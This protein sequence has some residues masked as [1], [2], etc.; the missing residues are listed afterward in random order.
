MPFCPAQLG[1]VCFAIVLLCSSA[2]AATLWNDLGA[3]LAHDT[4]DGQD[5]L[6]G[7][8]KR[9]DTS[10]DTLYFKFHVDPLSDVN[11]EEYF[12]GLELFDGE[13][14][15]LAVGNSMKAWAYSAF[16]TSEV[17]ELNTV[18]GDFDLHS[19]RPELTAVGVFKRYE[20][21]RRG[22]E[23]TIVFRVQYVPGEDDFVTVWLSP[24]LSPG[25]TETN[26]PE[27]LT[28]TFKA[29]CSF[30]EIHLRHGGGGDG[31]TFSDIAIATSFNDF[32]APSG[33]EP[34]KSSPVAGQGLLPFTFRSW[35][36]E[37]GLPQNSVRAL[38]QT[39]EGYLWIG[40]DN[41]LARFDGVRFVS[42]GE[43]EGLRCGAVSGI[44]EDR[45]GA[46]WIG[47][48][49]DGLTRWQDGKFITF[50]TKDGLPADSITA[51]AEDNDGRLWVGTAAGMGSLLDGRWTTLT[52]ETVLGKTITG[53]FEDKKG[54]LWVAVK[55]TGVFQF[56]DGKL[57]PV[58]DG[59]AE[60]LLRDPHCLLVDRHD[61]LW[62]GV[63][64][65]F[66]LCRDGSQWNR[67]RIPRH[68][69]RPFISTLAES[70]DGTVW[71]GSVSEGLFQFNDGKLIAINASSG[72]L[73]NVVESL[74]VDREG[75]LWV[76]TSAGLNQ[77][78]PKSVSCFGPEEGLGFG[79]VQGLAEIAP[80]KIWAGKASDGLYHWEGRNFS[81]LSL[82]GLSRNETQVNAVLATRD[83]G[84]WV[85]SGKGLLHVE[86][87]K[88]GALESQPTVLS[89]L[90]AISLAEDRDGAVW[91]GTHEGGVWRL[92][93]G[94]QTAMT[95]LWQ[96]RPVTAILQ[97]GDGSMWIGTD[98]DGLH[99][100]QGSAHI[101]YSKANGL[102]NDAIRAL[103]QDA[104]GVLW[105]GTA[106]GGLARW[107]DGNITVFT[108][109]EGL[110]DDTISQIIEDDAGRL[111]LGSNRGIASVSKVELQELAAGKTTTLYPRIFG[112]AEGMLSEECTGGFFPAGLKTKNGLLWFSTVKG[113]VV[114]DPYLKNAARRGPTVILEEVTL[115]GAPITAFPGADSKTENQKSNAGLP[116]LRIPPGQ[117]RI[118]LRYAGLN[119]TAPERVRF[120]YRLEGLDSD[121]VDAGGS[122]NVSY[123]FVP[124]GK[125]QFQVIACD[126]D[127]VWSESG[128]GVELTVLRYFWQTWWFIG[129]A[130]FGF[131]VFVGGTIR[132]L[133]RRKAQGQLKQL[134]RARE[135]ERERARIA[136]DLHD[137]LG[138]SLSR[139]SL[140]SDM[141]RVGQD[142]H[143][144]TGVHVD[145][146]SHLAGQTLR[147]LDEIVWAVRPGSDSLQSLVEY[148]A[149]FAGELFKGSGVRCRLD[150]P[151]TLPARSL[152]PEMRHNIFLIAK[153]ALTNTMKHASAS[154]VTVQ[155][156][157]D[158]NSLEI[159]IGDDGNG[160]DPSNSQSIREGNGLGN[161][162][163]RAEAVGGNLEMKSAP[164]KGTT[165]R[166]LVNFSQQQTSNGKRS[167]L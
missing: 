133:E 95:N 66:V 126:G 108:T 61:R 81:R 83:G 130:T 88:A 164:G 71:A 110:P 159:L 86:D 25:A 4:G 109:R 58:K 73:D 162:R 15:G 167:I 31:W 143:S 6:G 13:T 166:L 27:N 121:W 141:A 44:L 14:R 9:D 76:G 37:Q 16:H 39:R 60:R 97:G 142:S 3:T 54:I 135:L 127:G 79:A 158:A 78:R 10:A 118:E 55:G 137:D 48:V 19:S 103:H 12:A 47:S 132:F 105:I 74:L 11:T 131:F 138:A 136:Q 57:N 50:K 124:P 49:S 26:Q 153:E 112:R 115:D 72:I 45:C 67:Y 28:T 34:G 91:A 140:L 150:L 156:K 96:T 62:V 106:G 149:H 157:T 98:G 22:N 117:H 119:F 82:A 40:T 100:Y 114:I 87:P 123:P 75:N 30:N 35:Q 36:R 42:F 161:M 101:R 46:L 2:R 20:R 68:L 65:D 8:V 29:N 148:I 120:R 165:V 125:H 77:L 147:A 90:N 51:L 38:A 152:P 92:Q 129:L 122:R 69:D 43:R 7:V 5:I 53:L 144:Q 64:D 94:A 116:T 23:R 99:C 151:D 84:G 1:I 107:Q 102:L 56:Q 59:S 24:D 41:G 52:N 163:L 70:P 21:P 18:S 146:I 154:E 128:A 145:K 104:Q 63:G 89:E 155:V 111:W 32:V 80:G 93:G 17:G 85:A 139:I 113:L 160:F 134:E 33:I